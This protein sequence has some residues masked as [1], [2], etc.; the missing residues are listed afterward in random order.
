MSDPMADKS[1]TTARRDTILIGGK[2]APWNAVPEL[3]R[4]KARQ[5]GDKVFATID[6]RDVS[7]QELDVLSD[8]VAANLARMGIGPGA[9][10]ASVLSNCA[11]QVFGWIG[12]NRTGAIWAPLNAS[13]TGDD[14]LH[15][16]RNSGAQMLVTDAEGVARVMQLP[17]EIRSSVRLCLVDARHDDHDLSFASLLKPG[18]TPPRVQN[19]PGDPAMILYTGGTTGLPKGV[20]LPHFAIVSAGCRYG[21][22]LSATSADRHY[23]SLP[24]FHASGVQLGIVGP[25]L[26]DMTVVMDRRF[27]AS[28]YWQRVRDVGATIIDPISTM[29][30]VLVQQPAS[31]LDRQH[32]VRITTGVNAQIPPAVPEEFARR[33]GIPI[34][35]IYGQSETGGAMATSNRLGSQMPG[36]VGKPHGW[37]QVAILDENDCELPPGVQG[38]IALR[39]TV[40]FTFMLGYQNDAEA[41]RKVWRNLWFHSSDLGHLDEQGNLFF[42]GRQS[43]CLRRRGENISAYEIEAV[44]TRH[45]AVRETIV[46]GFPSELGEDDV[47]A[48]IVPEGDPPSE[49]ELI[50]W[51]LAS[52][53]AF[54]VPRYIAF[55]DDFP[56]SATKREVER[57]KMK[58]WPAT[59]HWD[60]DAV[61]GRLSPDALAKAVGLTRED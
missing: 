26:N 22:T 27:S 29:M 48:W 34:V 53:A 25:L 21:E 32:Q 15:T 7:Y 58:A 43:H 38:N 57:A 13:L 30:S 28:G 16:L 56:R 60:R 11:E 8:R 45:A 40:P 18:D 35:D 1:E 5:H 2:A 33:F 37:S 59:G 17:A 41:T 23:T 50:R 36:S 6:G 54:K 12:T 55:V 14:L 24:L 9:C 10:V 42:T 31:P 49:T 46:T 61:L 39:P 19:R 20:V 44:L 3:V 51:C 47:K 4:G 52:L